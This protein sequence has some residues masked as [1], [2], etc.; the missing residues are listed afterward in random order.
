MKG[1]SKKRRT[2]IYECGTWKATKMKLWV[3]ER[4]WQEGL[5]FLFDFTFIC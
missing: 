2:K 3:W 4:L 5:L 1:R